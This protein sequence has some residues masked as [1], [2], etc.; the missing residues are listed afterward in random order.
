MKNFRQFKEDLEA[1]A[2]G[3]RQ[4]RGPVT[5]TSSDNLQAQALQKRRESATEMS[6]KIRDRQL[7]QKEINKQKRK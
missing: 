4:E 2:S 1:I 5:N 3:G 6:N 7:R